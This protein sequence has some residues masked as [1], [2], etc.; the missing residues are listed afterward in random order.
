MLLEEKQGGGFH[1][2]GFGCITAS[3]SFEHGET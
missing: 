2:P 3:I 1:T